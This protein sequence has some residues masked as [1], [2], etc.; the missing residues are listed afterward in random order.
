MLIAKWLARRLLLGLAVALGLLWLAIFALRATGQLHVYVVPSSSM[1]PTLKCGDHVAVVRYL[2]GSP[3]RND[4]VA[5]RTSFDPAA[6][7]PDAV[8]IK[9]VAAIG[10]DRIEARDGHLLVNNRVVGL[11]SMSS[12]GPHTVARGSYFVLGDQREVSD[13]SRS[14]GD[15]PRSAII[16]R[17]VLVYWPLG[18][19][20][21]LT[22]HAP[23]RQSSATC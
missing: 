22:G 6:F 16:G 4:V 23:S 3:E 15:V 21:R 12:F 19:L 20:G 13:D 5:F 14:F 17:A 11:Y 9:R 8:F 10:G 7:N 1:S 2:F 18:R